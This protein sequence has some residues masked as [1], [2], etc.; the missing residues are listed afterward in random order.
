MSQVLAGKHALV[1]GGGSGIG[2]ESARLL[3]RDGA[4]VTIAGR[5]EQKLADA[6]GLLARDGLQVKYKVADGLVGADVRAAVDVAS[7]QGLLHI[8][9]AVPATGGLKP[10]LL[11]DDDQFS[12]EIDG[13]VRPVFLML[14][15]AGQAMVRAGG[16]S[17]VA[18]SSGVSISTPRFMASYAAGKAAVDRLVRVAADELGEAK[19]RV[20]SVLPG[21]T[22]TPSG[23]M[24]VGNDATRGAFLAQQPL[25]RLGEPEDV[26][27]AIRF[28]CGPESSFVT[29][30]ILS[31]DGGRTLR[32]FPDL[33]GTWTGSDWKEAARLT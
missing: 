13:N 22:R 1:M 28:F 29:G 32:A 8:A 15:Y 6:C 4:R 5:T 19:I 18:V 3:A 26:A 31:V 30:Q 17:F 16:G 10:L 23:Q 24:L 21:L 7:D 11:C 20:N 14:K 25:A 12:R 2:L 27:E 33:R 9:V